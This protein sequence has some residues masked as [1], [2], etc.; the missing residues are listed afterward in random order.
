MQTKHIFGKLTLLLFTAAMVAG[1]TSAM[2]PPAALAAEDDVL[3]SEGFES[4]AFPPA[5]WSRYRISGSTN[6]SR[7]FSNSH[8]GGIYSAGSGYG[9]GTREGWLVTPQIAI[10]AAG[11]YVLKF[12]S[13]NDWPRDLGYF[14]IWVSTEGNNPAA[15][16]F[17]EL[18]SLS[19]S[20]ISDSWK[21][22][23]VQLSPD[24]N[25]Q[26][27][28]IGFRYQDNKN[29]EWYI[30]DVSVAPD[31][32]IPVTNITGMLPIAVINNI[33]SLNASVIPNDANS[34][35]VT[36]SLVDAAGTGATVNG[37]SFRATAEGTAVIRA[38]VEN[39]IAPGVDFTKDFSIALIASGSGAFQVG[40][41]IYTTLN[42]AVAAVPDGG[43]I[44]MLNNVSLPAGD[45]TMNVDKNYTL[46]LNGFT[47]SSFGKM[48]IF[49]IGAGTVTIKNG[50]VLCDGNGSNY[51]GIE[52]WGGA[53]IMEN[54]K[55]YGKMDAIWAYD[56]TIHILSGEYFGIDSAIHLYYATMVITSG[57][58]S[59]EHPLG[60]C[61]DP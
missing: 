23:V 53:V 36:W 2:T 15:S 56:G 12:W 35:G 10:P 25:G 48:S 22:I 58:F 3:L 20:E 14:G 45:G 26:N 32:Y 44:K 40:E 51:R 42:E 18:K 37:N 41:S 61:I 5:G 60:Y 43:T 49:Y 1:L 54:L 38:T 13:Y 55:V 39:G 52:I 4:S 33:I 19:S 7:T 59:N 50:S 16:S 17:V 9:S 21:L 24:Y 11:A 46:D 28:N 29:D 57:R 30:D 8:E 34:Q 27:I 47:V 6:W 31:T